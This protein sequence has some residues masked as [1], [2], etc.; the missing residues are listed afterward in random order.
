MNRVLF[1]HDVFKPH[2]N[3]IDSLDKLEKCEYTDFLLD[4]A[5]RMPETYKPIIHTEDE[6]EKYQEL[7]HGDYIIKGNERLK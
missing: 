7:K 6:K 3:K 5:V 4:E 2:F 1:N